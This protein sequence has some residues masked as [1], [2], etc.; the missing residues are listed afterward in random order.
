MIGMISAAVDAVLDSVTA[1]PAFDVLVADKA[2]GSLQVEHELQ[3]KRALLNSKIG[4]ANDMARN[5]QAKLEEE[6]A[7]ALHRASIKVAKDAR[8]LAPLFVEYRLNPSRKVALEIAAVIKKLDDQSRR[9]QGVPLD[10]F[11]VLTTW[12]EALVSNGEGED[13]KAVFSSLGAFSNGPVEAATALVRAACERSVSE[14]EDA[15]YRLESAL[16]TAI[17][18]AAAR[19]VRRCFRSVR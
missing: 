2:K 13:L 16:D 19:I 12:V 18:F 3:A 8:E 17:R 14:I 1:L 11:V 9:V 4:E 15:L 5:A 7:A 6:H 10:H